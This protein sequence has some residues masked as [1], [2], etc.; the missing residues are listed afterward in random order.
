MPPAVAPLP[1]IFEHERG[2]LSLLKTDLVFEP[3]TWEAEGMELPVAS[4]VRPP[5][6]SEQR[7]VCEARGDAYIFHLER[8]YLNQAE[9]LCD[10]LQ[11]LVEVHQPGLLS[12]RDQNMT[13]QA[14]DAELDPLDVELQLDLGADF[15]GADEPLV[16][17]K[18]ALSPD[19]ASLAT[20]DPWQAG[21]SPKQTANSFTAPTAAVANA[22]SEPTPRQS[23]DRGPTLTS[24]EQTSPVA[25]APEERR[26]KLG[27][28][29]SFFKS[30]V[31]DALHMINTRQIKGPAS[32]AETSTGIPVRSRVLVNGRSGLLAYCGMVHFEAGEWA[33]VYLEEPVGEHDGVHSSVRYFTC[34]PR[35]GIMVQVSKVRLDRHRKPWRN[36]AL[37]PFLRFPMPV[38]NEED[39]AKPARVCK[40]CYEP[41]TVINSLNPALWKNKKLT[42][43]A[44][45]T[46]LAAQAKALQRIRDLFEAKGKDN[47]SWG[48]SYSY[49]ACAVLFLCNSA[50]NELQRQAI[51]CL[52]VCMSVAPLLWFQLLDNG[53]LTVFSNLILRQMDAAVTVE[54]LKILHQLLTTNSAMHDLA[55]EADL[56]AALMTAMADGTRSTKIV[57]SQI[58]KLLAESRAC[59]KSIAQVQE[60]QNMRLLMTHAVLF[61]LVPPAQEQLLCA[62]AH[63][64]AHSDLIRDVYATFKAMAMP[65]LICLANLQGAN[66]V[67]NYEAETFRTRSMCHIVCILANMS[68]LA[69]DPELD[70][71]IILDSCMSLQMVCRDQDVQQHLSRYAAVLVNHL[72]PFLSPLEAVPEP[73]TATHILSMLTHIADTCPRDLA[74]NMDDMDEMLDRY[75]NAEHQEHRYLVQKVLAL[76]DA[77]TA[78]NVVCE[79]ETRLAPPTSFYAFDPTISTK[80][81]LDARPAV[82]ATA[83]PQDNLAKDNM[84]L[85]QRFQQL[86]HDLDD[87]LTRFDKLLQD[88]PPKSD[89]FKLLSERRTALLAR[90]SELEKTLA[91]KPVPAEASAKA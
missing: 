47:Y 10:K 30:G 33:G 76:L 82:M 84:V 32:E 3:Q 64:S 90:R 78:Q 20:L 6:V 23:L 21:T 45:K 39:L 12:M 34:P 71:Y 58:I 4:L 38:W 52:R 74:Q 83:N 27:S 9:A 8:E 50:V 7:L 42:Y 67:G 44:S 46:T 19:T 65:L 81:V 85:Q 91:G 70:L 18:R 48:L 22:A 35:H 31:Q 60:G 37:Q 13:D 56:P 66:G 86:H 55:I 51:A 43:A 17:P 40:Q 2:Y 53:L 75:L 11:A 72:R 69:I 88:V 29:A 62:L 41:C 1:V 36:L 16:I 87:Q 5:Y 57:A 54:A 26:R 63:V 80:G 68:T 49:L 14:F 61:Y 24:Q 79:I 25:P 73:A 59:A 15:E 89:T 77:R 28:L